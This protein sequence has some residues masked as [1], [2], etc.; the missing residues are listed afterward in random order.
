[1]MTWYP[2]NQTILSSVSS[3]GLIIDGNGNGGE[4][5]I[6]KMELIQLLNC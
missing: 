3:L 1:M 6:L 5:K 2:T 4:F